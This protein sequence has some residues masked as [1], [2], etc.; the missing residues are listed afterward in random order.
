M[1]QSTSVK[2]KSSKWIEV[3]NEEY[4]SMQDNM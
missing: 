1:T 2:P 3:M 4:K